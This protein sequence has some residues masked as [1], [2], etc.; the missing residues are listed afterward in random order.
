[1]DA[2]L[3]STSSSASAS[4]TGWG[5]RQRKDRTRGGKTQIRTRPQGGKKNKSTGS[6]ALLVARAL[7][8]LELPPTE[9]K[10]QSIQHSV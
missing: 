3:F 8:T 9:E 2:V 5:K 4:S 10:P 7:S 1:M 6:M